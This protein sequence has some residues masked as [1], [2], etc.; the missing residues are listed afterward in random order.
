MIP[1]D[2]YAY[3]SKL[4]RIDPKAKLWFSLLPLL[5]CI[6]LDSFS[7]SLVCLAVMSWATLQSGTL[8]ARRYLSFLSLPM[9]FLILGTA[10]LLIGRYP[11]HSQ[12]L[13]AVSI[14]SYD[15]GIS[16]NSLLEGAGLILKSLAAV[17]CMYFL[18]FTTPMVSLFETLRRTPLPNLLVS[19]ME[20]IYRYIFVIWEEAQTM[21]TAQASRLGYTGFVRSLKSAGS[22]AAAVFFRAYQKCDRSFAALE[23]RGYDGSLDALE[24]SYLPGNKL[25]ASAFLLSAVLLLLSIGE[26]ILTHGGISL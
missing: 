23:S 2:G 24:E 5:L 10:T 8:S 18:A 22:L 17:S 13:C 19:L 11:H 6:L 12:L 14:G 21:R 1:I 16:L 3:A 26:G 9:A 15:Y 4:A 7:V 20:L 25:K